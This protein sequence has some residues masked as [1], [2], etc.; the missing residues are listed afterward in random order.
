MTDRTIPA[1]RYMSSPVLAVSPSASLTDVDR[2]LK[3]HGISSLAVTDDDR[4]M[5][6]IS[7]TDLLRAGRRHAVESGSTALLDLPDQRVVEV[8]SKDAITITTDTPLA[9]AAATM[10][11]REFHRMFVTEGDRCVGVLSTR[12]VMRAL[13]DHRIGGTI[14]EV[15]SKP[16]FTVEATATLA[17]ATERLERAGIS[18]VVV[19]EQDWPVGV[20]TQVDA[21]RARRFA[22]GVPVEDVMN[23]AFVCM[24]DVTTIHRA[25]AQ[26]LA[27]RV[28]RIIAV[29]HRDMVGV[30]TGIDFARVAARAEVT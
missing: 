20:Y 9:A 15:M 14:G 12:D 19:V 26:A 18:G 8:M 29:Q 23:S 22:A 11:E 10:V 6:V 1:G 16:V 21:L 30:L 28:R 7:R 27:L 4:L 5:G 13:G 3:H 24:P 17:A 2:R 25:A